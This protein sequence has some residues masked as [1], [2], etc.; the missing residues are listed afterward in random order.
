[1]NQTDAFVMGQH[2]P[3]FG[4]LQVI[5]YLVTTHHDFTRHIMEEIS[6]LIYLARR[7]M[8]NPPEELSELSAM[9]QQ[10]HQ[11]ML[12]HLRE[13]EEIL[14]PWIERQGQAAEA[15]AVVDDQIKHMLV[16]HKH[17]EESMERVK[18]LADQLS[19]KGGYIPVL[20]RLA[21]KLKQLNTDLKEH[22]EIE[23]GLLFPRMQGKS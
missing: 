20:A 2:L 23:T 8:V 13:E 1:M 16:E 12:E 10:Y 14:F 18:M 5:S 3:K 4:N 22:M 7:E 21:Y 11:G 15:G 19:E 6:E 17:H 9:W